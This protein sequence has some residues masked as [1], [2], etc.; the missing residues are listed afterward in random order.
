MVKVSIESNISDVNKHLEELKLYIP[1]LGKIIISRISY[2]GRAIARKSYKRS[3][4]TTR[5]GALY[6]AIYGSA[7]TEYAGYIGI[8]SKQAYKFIPLNYGGSHTP[9]RG[10]KYLTFLVGNRWVSVK[11]TTIPARN[12]FR[13]AIDYTKSSEM[14]ND[15]NK[16]AIKQIGKMYK[17]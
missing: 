10:A 4:I 6:K 7:K 15:I 12:F 11:A 16:I 2:K 13:D 8:A 17:I 5:T 9:T 14:A 3:H 1:K